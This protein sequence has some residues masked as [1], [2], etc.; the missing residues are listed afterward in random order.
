M[1]NKNSLPQALALNVE[2]LTFTR[3]Q[4]KIETKQNSKN[5]GS[6]L[7]EYNLY[8]TKNIQLFMIIE[9]YSD[10]KIRGFKK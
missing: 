8:E 4:Q 7:M 1:S 5:K 6:H 2:H 3:R 9:R 10:L